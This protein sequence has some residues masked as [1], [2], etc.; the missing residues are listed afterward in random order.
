LFFYFILSIFT[1]F[2][3]IGHLNR[4][5][6]ENLLRSL[7]DSD[8]GNEHMEASTDQISTEAVS[9]QPVSI[10]ETSEPAQQSMNETEQMETELPNG[11]D[12]NETEMKVEEEEPLTEE[13]GFLI[14][15]FCEMTGCDPS[16]A[17]TALESTAWNIDTAVSLH[18]EGS[19]SGFSRTNSFQPSVVRPPIT[20][21][22]MSE[23]S[24][25]SE[26]PHP[27]TGI[28]G[29]ADWERLMNMRRQMMTEYSSSSSGYH[30]A[31]A[32][33]DDDDDESYENNRAV[34]YDED[35]VRRPDPVRLQRL[36]SRGY[37][38]ESSALNRAD[39]H[40]IDWLF[41]PPRHLSSQESFENVCSRCC[42]V[43][44]SVFFLFR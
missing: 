39:D 43:F 19:S 29:A 14:S 21:T 8:A 42:F 20:T 40:N 12:T 4:T 1:P 15:Q 7:G 13:Q 27:L 6:K 41:P 10:M 5:E 37:S 26:F 31:H 24:Q 36:I 16:L 44:S 23:G 30:H 9:T 25:I 38:H 32:S 3:D 33:M 18:L 22:M 34:E 35:G 11:D 28:A 2:Q 17:K